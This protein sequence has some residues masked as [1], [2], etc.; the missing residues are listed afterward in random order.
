VDRGFAVCLAAGLGGLLLG[1]AVGLAAALGASL[2]PVL[3]ELGMV[4]ED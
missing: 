1:Y 2:L 4:R 3:A